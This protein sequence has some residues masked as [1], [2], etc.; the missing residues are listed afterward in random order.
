MAVRKDANDGITAGNSA[1]FVAELQWVASNPINFLF[2]RLKTAL[3]DI[4]LYNVKQS[5][6][7]STMKDHSVSIPAIPEG[8]LSGI[9]FFDRNLNFRCPEADRHE[10]LFPRPC[11]PSIRIIALQ[12]AVIEFF[13][14]V[15]YLRPPTRRNRRS[16]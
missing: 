6:R 14:Q 2:Y 4:P 8:Q 1:I 9:Q 7:C 3:C 5:P 10:V 16:L 11:G 15:I 13:A 12:K